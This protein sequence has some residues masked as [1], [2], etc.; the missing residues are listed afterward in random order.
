MWLRFVVGTWP[1]V[2]STT[3]SLPRPGDRAEAGASD[4]GETIIIPVH[5]LEWLGALSQVEHQSSRRPSF[6]HVSEGLVDLLEPARLTDHPSAPA[7][8]SSNVSARSTRVPTIEPVTVIPLQDRLEDRQRH[9]VVGG[10][11]DEDESAAPA[12]RGEGLL[13][14]LRRSGQGDRRVGAAQG[15]DGLGRILRGRR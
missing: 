1:A 11:P 2:P 3:S 4:G 12:E 7:A 8:W 10:E 5:P 14:Q 9:A 15:L 13:E 6:E